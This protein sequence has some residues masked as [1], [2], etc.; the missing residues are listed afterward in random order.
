MLH[1]YIYDISRLRV[2]SDFLRSQHSTCGTQS[3]I[4]EMNFGD[5]CVCVHVDG[6]WA[7]SGQK[8]PA[9]ICWGFPVNSRIF[10]NNYF[11]EFN[12]SNMAR[13]EYSPVC[14]N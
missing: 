7:N 10:T 3:C 2:K 5:V 11:I 8:K 9:F 13:S 6:L 1:I 4:C 12:A 14:V